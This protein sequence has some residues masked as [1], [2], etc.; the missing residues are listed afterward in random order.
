MI[1]ITIF[2]FH[3][4]NL[5]NIILID[6]IRSVRIFYETA[7]G[8]EPIMIDLQSIAFSILA[9]PS[10]CGGSE[11][12]THT[13]DFSSERFSKPLQY[14]YAYPSFFKTSFGSFIEFIIIAAQAAIAFW[15]SES[16][17]LIYLILI[18][19][20][21]LECINDILNLMY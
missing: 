21:P 12:R 19:I 6:Y 2:T 5:T 20:Y 13:P 17:T 16:R 10:Y 14:H 8:L 7:K 11:T 9:K 1:I 15:Y 18:S 3:N 4:S